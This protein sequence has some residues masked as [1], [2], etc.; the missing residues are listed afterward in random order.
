MDKKRICENISFVLIDDNIDNEISRIYECLKKNKCIDIKTEFKIFYNAFTG[1]KL[2]KI[3]GKIK[4]IKPK[5]LCF[6]LILRLLHTRKIESTNKHWIQLE[7]LFLDKNG[8]A[9]SN[10]KKESAKIGVSLVPVEAPLID[11]CLIRSIQ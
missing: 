10:G 2:N 11:N 4:W 1:K 6:Y 5:V 3:D 9:I 8:R 7:N